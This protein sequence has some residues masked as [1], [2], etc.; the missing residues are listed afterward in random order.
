MGALVSIEK[1]RQAIEQLAELVGDHQDPALQEA[2][3]LLRNMIS[4]GDIS[5]STGVA[6]GENIRL[7]VNQLNLPPELT[8]E[9][10]GLRH[11]LSTSLGLDPERYQLGA[12]L[13]D[14]TRNFV[15]REHVFKAIKQFCSTH[16]QGY[17]IIEGDPGIGKSSILAEY[18]R[19]EACIAHFNT[20]SLGVTT[21]Q[22]FLESVCS[23]LIVEYGLPYATVVPEQ[24]KDG[25]F[26]SHLLEEAAA[27]LKSGE[28]LIIAVDAL[29]E[30]NFDSKSLTNLLYLP[31][32][33]P[34][35]VYFILTRRR[36]NMPLVVQS[37]I[38][39]F[40]LMRY[41][42]ENRNDVETFLWN[43]SERPGIRAWIARQEHPTADAFVTRL[44]DLSE[45][46]FMYLRYM[47]PE[48]EN[49]AYTNMSFKSLPIG[50]EGYY[51]DHWLHMGMRATPLPRA[52]IRIVYILCEV[53]EPVS[54]KLIA[55][56]ATDKAIQVDELTVQETLDEWDQF[57]HKQSR[58]AANSYSVYH[59]SFRDFL[60]RKDVVQAAGVT[61]P[62]IHAL[63]ADNLW[64]DL[65]GDN[66]RA[67][68]DL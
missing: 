62:D 31:A 55:E 34:D 21:V 51:D 10:L 24:T 2:V 23:Q 7:V 19:R 58:N 4:V 17:F 43:S 57:L 16:S 63:I 5:N 13:A 18:V 46:N 1:A 9:L 67:Q 22:Q 14:K 36:V 60:H 44:A 42:A 49:G 15:G 48:I 25:V 65:F 40:D 52:K 33:L 11:T 53:R 47:L 30:L 8:A 45:N 35:K 6:I 59:T 37:P 50:L 54:R 3:Q 28:K 56:F 26:F 27:K 32:V 61:I 64:S 20:Q 38:E 66:Q 39:S 29:D 41:P 12:L 68:Q